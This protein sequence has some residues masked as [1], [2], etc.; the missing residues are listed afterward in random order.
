MRIRRI[1]GL[2]LANECRKF[3]AECVFGMHSRKISR[4]FFFPPIR[5][6]RPMRPICPV[7][8]TPSICPCVLAHQIR[9]KNLFFPTNIHPFYTTYIAT[10]QPS[11]ISMPPKLKD[12]SQGFTSTL[13]PK[14]S[15]TPAAKWNSEEITSMV[16][17]LVQ[18]KID[19]ET[20][21]NGFKKSVWNRVANS[22]EDPLKK[23]FR[24][25]ETK[26]SRMKKEYKEVKKLHKETSGFGWDEKT[27]L[28]TAED[29][30]WEVLGQV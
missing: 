29:S 21:E 16:S 6:M 24:V 7:R 28:V 1:L 13:T 3:S 9:K 12:P 23:N 8:P 22:F 18:A 15:R 25:C 19:G 14:K 17:Q 27:Q 26:F 20:S 2:N 30:V 4:K 10:I 11:S 5:P